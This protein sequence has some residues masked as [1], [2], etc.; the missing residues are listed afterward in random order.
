MDYTRRAG[1]TCLLVIIAL[2]GIGFIPAQTICGVE[3][4]RV[5]ILGDLLSYD[6]PASDFVELE[7]DEEEY[8]VDLGEVSR[9]VTAVDSSNSE[10]LLGELVWESEES[11]IASAPSEPLDLESSLLGSDVQL[12]PIEDFDTTA[13]SPLKRL[14]AKLQSP[15]SLVRVAFLGDSFVEGDILTS[16][17]REAL[18][19]RFGGSGCGFA[20]M[21]SPLTNFRPTIKT[22]SKGWDSYNVMQKRTTAE[23][24]KNMFPI[25]GWVCHPTANGSSV[26]WTTT[27]AREHIDS[28]ERVR[29]LFVSHTKSRLEVVINGSKR[30]SFDIDAGDN[31]RQI[32]LHDSAI[33]SVELTISEGADGFV[34]YGAIFESKRGVVV[35]NYSVR[36]NNGQAMFW[37]SASINAQIDRMIGGYDLVVL[38]Y[39]LNIMQRGVGNYSGYATQVGKMIAYVRE[40]FPRAAV[41]VMGVSDRSMKSDG[42]YKPME[43]AVKLNNYQREAACEAGAAYWNTYEAMGA[44]GGMS[45]FVANGWAGKDFTHINFKGGRQ[46]ALA[47]ADGVIDGVRHSAIFTIERD[48]II[49]PTH[50]RTIREA[51]LGGKR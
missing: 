36:S 30:R 28:C 33:R 40:C 23:P 2:I 42:E 37:T 10:Q 38:Q 29:I 9:A 4:R 44:Q 21:A 11:K 3:L 6:E 25:S 41:V 48:P 35:D 18:Q 45:R 50:D 8:E 19:G 39:G 24:Y 27:E 14:Y 12:T 34:G 51:L 26:K 31:L 7:I 5:N 17:L 43:E 46:V 47:L 32:E 16:D 13:M 22:L 1:V 15:D 20:P 49:T